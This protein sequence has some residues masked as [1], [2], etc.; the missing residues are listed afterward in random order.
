LAAKNPG[1]RKI[2]PSFDQAGTSLELVFDFDVL[3]KGC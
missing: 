2:D 3:K 1:A